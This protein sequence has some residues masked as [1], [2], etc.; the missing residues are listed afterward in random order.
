[1]NKRTLPCT[2]WVF[3]R[4]RTNLEIFQITIHEV[5]ECEKY[6]IYEKGK[7]IF[8][9]PRKVFSSLLPEEHVILPHNT[10]RT[11]IERV[12]FTV[13][14]LLKKFE[15]E[16]KRFIQ[17]AEIRFSTTAESGVKLE[18]ILKELKTNLLESKKRL[19]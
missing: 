8:L 11:S 1:M 16:K 5:N 7:C 12:T 10:F 13:E 17:D 4:V 18:E 6:V 19:E 15:E 14:E 9:G 3:Y 2:G